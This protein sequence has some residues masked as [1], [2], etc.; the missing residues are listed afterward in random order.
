[1]SFDPD[2][3][4]LDEPLDSIDLKHRARIIDLLNDLREEGV[5][6]VLSTQK[7]EVLPELVD[8]AYLFNSDK[9]FVKFDVLREIITDVKLLE[10]S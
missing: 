1:M 4:L 6:L 9:R 3:L 2:L 7:L 8:K 5:T 10:K